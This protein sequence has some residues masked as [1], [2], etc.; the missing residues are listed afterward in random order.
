MN[1]VH[2]THIVFENLSNINGD[3]LQ[4]AWG[5]NNGEDCII[6]TAPSHTSLADWGIHQLSKD[7]RRSARAPYPFS[8]NRRAD[9][10]NSS[11]YPDYPLI[12]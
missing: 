2:E 4:K 12:A 3:T 1:S 6:D 10:R 7:V 8:M 11:A 5:L 9:L